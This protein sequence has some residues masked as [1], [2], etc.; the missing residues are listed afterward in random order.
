MDMKRNCALDFWRPIIKAQQK[1][2]RFHI[3]LRCALALSPTSADVECL[4]SLLTRINRADRRSLEMDVLEK[5]LIVAWDSLPFTVYDFDPV[6]E[7]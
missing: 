7:V 4:F 5:L 1:F 2:P 3:I 6:V